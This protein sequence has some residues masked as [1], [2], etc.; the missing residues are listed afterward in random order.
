MPDVLL[1]S[2]IS[3][4]SFDYPL[5]SR[6]SLVFL[7]SLLALSVLSS[8]SSSSSSFSSSSFSSSSRNFPFD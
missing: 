4:L 1:L 7:F 6:S 2:R 3:G 5:L 8:S